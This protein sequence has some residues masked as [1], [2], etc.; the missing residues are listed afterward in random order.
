[1]ANESVLAG[2]SA[3]SGSSRL[4]NARLTLVLAT[5]ELRIL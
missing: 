1:M 2:T 4:I 3:Q 5:N